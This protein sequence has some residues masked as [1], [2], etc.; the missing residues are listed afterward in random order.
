ME[1]P[2]ITQSGAIHQRQPYRYPKNYL[3]VAF[4]E[5]LVHQVVTAYM[6]GGRAGTKA[7]KTRAKS[8]VV[9]L[10]LGNKK[11]QDVHAPVQFAAHYGVAAV[12][13]LLR[14]RVAI[15]KK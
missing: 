13:Y 10:N 14:L 8:A 3:L 15:S 2:V 1:L 12:K 5:G 4:N 6:A 7:Q 11:A 9:V